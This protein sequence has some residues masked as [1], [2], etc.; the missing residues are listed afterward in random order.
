MLRGGLAAN[1]GPSDAADATRFYVKGSVSYQAFA[2]KDAA[3]EILSE[4]PLPRAA[5]EALLKALQTTPAQLLK[6]AKKPN[7]GL[8]HPAAPGESAAAHSARLH[9]LWVRQ[10]GE[11]VQHD[12]VEQ[13]ALVANDELTNG[14][15]LMTV[16]VKKREPAR[17]RGTELTL[18]TAK[19]RGDALVAAMLRVPAPLRSLLWRCCAD[20]WRG[21][22]LDTI[23]GGH[24]FSTAPPSFWRADAWLPAQ[25]WQL[26]AG[27]PAVTTD[28]HGVLTRNFVFKQTDVDP[29]PIA[30]G[31][32][33][34]AVAAVVNDFGGQLSAAE[35][36]FLNDLRVTAANGGV[37][38][39]RYAAVRSA[40]PPPNAGQLLMTPTET[41]ALGQ[42]VSTRLSRFALRA[43]TS[44]DVRSAD[45]KWLREGARAWLKGALAARD[46]WVNFLA[47][48]KAKP[49]APTPEQALAAKAN[50]QPGPALACAA[51]GALRRRDLLVMPAALFA[52]TLTA[53]GRARAAA[54]LAFTGLGDDV[55]AALVTPKSA[56][57]SVAAETPASGTQA[58]ASAWVLVRVVGRARIVGLWWAQ[59]WDR[60]RYSTALDFELGRAGD[61]SVAAQPLMT[62]A[63]WAAT[64]D[65]DSALLLRC[66]ATNDAAVDPEGGVEGPVYSV[67]REATL[68]LHVVACASLADQAYT[69]IVACLP[70]H[71]DYVRPN[72]AAACTLSI[73]GFARAFSW[74]HQLAEQAA[75]QD[76]GVLAETLVNDLYGLEEADAARSE[77]IAC[78]SAFAV[79]AEAPVKTLLR[80]GAAAALAARAAVL[81]AGLEGLSD[82]EAAKAWADV[83]DDSTADGDDLDVCFMVSA[84]P[85]CG[86][87]F[88]LAALATSDAAATERG[89]GF[90][91]AVPPRSIGIAGGYV[92]PPAS[93]GAPRGKPTAVVRWSS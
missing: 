66:C 14:E 21:G 72:L 49:P 12:M 28:D 26:V 54:D 87:L 93:L 89:V 61:D 37:R 13:T 31:E 69:S 91:G 92:T 20:E 8:L 51:A 46:E 67:P 53:A 70:S 10:W 11:R 50:L 90:Q 19:L 39:A 7:G 60:S 80:S 47:A 6:A 76:A 48:A 42:W 44:W 18:Q 63:Q 82:G 16:Q 9:A 75:E 30:D 57:Y 32:D 24:P 23:L 45:G 58:F 15:F 40:V 77:A 55:C 74:R 3:N 86:R 79:G 35:K 68:L 22:A 83:V 84:F 88:G 25:G 36:A 17:E 56:V 71:G 81:R 27:E 34:P 2:R 41:G 62:E 64:F 73:A 43:P 29:L 59:S 38:T 78:A 65:A 33:A 4:V 1:Q 85:T 52:A 5:V